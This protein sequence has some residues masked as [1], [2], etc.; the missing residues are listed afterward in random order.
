MT[1]ACSLKCN[2]HSH[3]TLGTLQYHYNTPTDQNHTITQQE[4]LIRK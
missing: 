3:L 2:I 1:R 4:I